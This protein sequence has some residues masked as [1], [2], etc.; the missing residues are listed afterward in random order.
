M[1]YSIT[2]KPVATPEIFDKEKIVDD[3]GFVTAEKQIFS[4]IQAG[5][6][7]KSIRSEQFDFPDGNIDESFID[8]TRET[9]FDLADA[10]QILNGITPVQPENEEDNI[11][12]SDTQSGSDGDTDPPSDK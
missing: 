4:L 9:N 1:F 6:R 10:S 7:L 3:T 5:A 8:P 12:V 11:D 2:N